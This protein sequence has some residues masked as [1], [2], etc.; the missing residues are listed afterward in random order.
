MTEEIPQL[1]TRSLLEERIRTLQIRN[2]QLNSDLND[3][4]RAL[5]ASESR[6]NDLINRINELDRIRPGL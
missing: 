3:Y 1:S 6:E 4:K 5:A 2:A